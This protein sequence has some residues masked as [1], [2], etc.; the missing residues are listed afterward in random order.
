MTPLVW[1]ALV[2]LLAGGLLAVYWFVLGRKDKTATVSAPAAPVADED[3]DEEL[4]DREA[5]EALGE[6]AR[7]DAAFE[8]AAHEDAASTRLLE[9]ALDDPVEAV[10]LA[11]AHSLVSSGRGEV[12]DRYVKLHPGARAQ[13]VA[14]MTQLLSSGGATTASG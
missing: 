2:A 8:A 1:V 13:R 5:F 4:E 12:L 14:S 10:A 6:G 9:R 7:C 3:L 11:A